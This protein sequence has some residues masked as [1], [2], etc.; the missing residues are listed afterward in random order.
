MDYN[1]R[2]SSLNR[3]YNPDTIRDVEL[4]MFAN[5][6]SLDKDVIRYVRRAMAP[7]DSVYT[8][9]TK[10][11]GET[12][13]KHLSEVLTDVSYEY[14]GSVMTNTHILG[15]SD[16]DLLVICDKFV[17]TDILKI[18][19]ELEKRNDYNYMELNRLSSYSRSFSSYQGNSFLDLAH[20]RETVEKKMASTYINCDITKPKAV[21]ITNLNLH[22]DVDIVTSSWFQSFEYV[23]KGQPEEL[24]AINIYNK[25]KKLAEGPDFPFL[26][27][28]RINAKDNESLGVLKKLIRF[29]KNVKKDSEHDIPLSSFEI[30]AICY[31]FS[32]E[33]HKYKN[34][35]DLLLP[36]WSY[37]FTLCQNENYNSLKSVVGDE[38]VFRGRPDK[39]KALHSLT[40]EV[41]N[42]YSDLMR[43]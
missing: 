30:N 10:E 13:K 3:R 29:L 12:V 37:M 11:A 26:S 24:R 32:T 23:I 31:S 18:R 25:Q 28:H 43:L 1:Q 4:R 38:Y 2:L 14:Q 15:T 9:K 41:Y 21:R 34:D 33:T 17:G 39:I 7:V 42:I 19:E 35:K 22:R 5:E 16:I 8:L 27:I 6:S 40:S 20:I 36:L